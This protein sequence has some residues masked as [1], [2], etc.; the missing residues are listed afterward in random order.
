MLYNYDY[1]FSPLTCILSPSLIN[2][3]SDM[4]TT[5]KYGANLQMLKGL[6]VIRELKSTKL[7]SCNTVFHILTI[8][9]KT[10]Q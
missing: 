8:S 7:Y 10:Q 6:D 4:K 9:L 3:Q 2:T 5:N 1:N